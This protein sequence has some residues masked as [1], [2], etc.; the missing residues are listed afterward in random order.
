MEKY[1]HGPVAIV[2]GDEPGFFNLA[3]RHSVQSDRERSGFC[4]VISRWRVSVGVSEADREAPH[5]LMAD[6][7]YVS[8]DFQRC[9]LPSR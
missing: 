1:G 3:A 9:S 6:E 4:A 8:L 5:V 7:A 2:G